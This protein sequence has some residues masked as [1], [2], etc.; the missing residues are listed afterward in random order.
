MVCTSALTALMTTLSESVNKRENIAQQTWHTASRARKSNRK[1]WV[2]HCSQLYSGVPHYRR[3][4]RSKPDIHYTRKQE[5]GTCDVNLRFRERDH[6][7]CCVTHPLAEAVAWLA[8]DQSTAW[9]SLSNAARH[10]Q[11]IKYFID[12]EKNKTVSTVWLQVLETVVTNQDRLPTTPQR[13]VV[14]V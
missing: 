6:K 3:K 5:T 4:T 11:K 1:C 13:H 8:R 12:S 10:Q 9:S 7:P 2:V 14:L